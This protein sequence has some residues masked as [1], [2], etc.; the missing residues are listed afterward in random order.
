MLKVL[1]YGGRLTVGAA[2]KSR[3][4]SIKQSSGTEA[5]SDCDSTATHRDACQVLEQV[6]WIMMPRKCLYWKEV[7]RDLEGGEQ[8]DRLD[9]L[10][11]LTALLQYS[12]S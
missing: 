6:F 4:K 5:E 9:N 8:C 1:I 3:E 12:P 7:K 10:T 11:V 2:V